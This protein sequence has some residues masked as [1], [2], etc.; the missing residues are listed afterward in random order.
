[1][2]SLLIVR[3]G[4]NSHCLLVGSAFE[5]AVHGM[6]KMLPDSPCRTWKGC[7]EAADP[8]GVPSCPS[9]QTRAFLHASVFKFFDSSMWKLSSEVSRCKES[10]AC[11]V[12]FVIF[13]MCVWFH[14]CSCTFGA[15]TGN[16]FRSRP[17]Q[18]LA[19]PQLKPQG[20]FYVEEHVLILFSCSHPKPCCKCLSSELR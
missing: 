3:P 17:V 7:H 9:H 5:A 13:S 4:R 14:S 11:M 20:T 18:M 12:I 2:L 10:I 1:M 15:S 8:I 6:N 19:T 16:S